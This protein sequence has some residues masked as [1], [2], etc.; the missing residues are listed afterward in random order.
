MPTVYA[1]LPLRGR[2]GAAGR[3]ILRGAELA[4]GRAGAAPSALVALDA[5]GGDR[6]ERAEANARR[7][8]ADPDAA[9]YLGDFHSSQVG[10]TGPILADAGILQVAPAA[11]FSGLGAATLIRLMPDD[12]ALAGAIA[13]WAVTAGVRRPVVV[14]DHDRGYGVPVGG[15]CAAAAKARGLDVRSRPVWDHDEAVVADVGDADAVIYVGAPGSGA[16][17]LWNR[18]YEIDP[19]MWLAA[20]DAL[21][22]PWFASEIIPGAA[23]RTRFFSAQRAPWGFYGFEAAALILDALAAGGRDRA[24]A[25]RAARAMRDRDS[26]LGRYSIDGEGLTTGPADGRLAIVDGVIVWERTD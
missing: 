2:A 20:T 9:A 1:S 4:L 17:A 12:R 23:G 19:R 13:D 18:L 14:H 5:S 24:G 3:D 7:A 22:V 6:D 11:T 15:M 10:R 16:V 21:A 8:A 26:V 25:V